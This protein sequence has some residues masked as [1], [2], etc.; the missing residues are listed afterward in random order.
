MLDTS[1]LLHFF[2]RYD[3]R[4]RLEDKAQFG[5]K[6]ILPQRLSVEEEKLEE[7]LDRE[8]YLALDNDILDVELGAGQSFSRNLDLAT[9]PVTCLSLSLSL[10]LSLTLAVSFPS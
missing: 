2:S 6:P 1:W 4:N 5:I 7:E 3:I 9:T 8:R 10:S